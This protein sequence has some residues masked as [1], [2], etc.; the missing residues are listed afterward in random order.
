MLEEKNLVRLTRALSSCQRKFQQRTFK[1]K[2][3]IAG[4][5]FLRDCSN[6][7]GHEMNG[8]FLVVGLKAIQ[9]VGVD[10]VRLRIIRRFEKTFR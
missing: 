9:V 4:S 6:I 8:D 3:N 7:E 10:F 2:H 1:W 5:P